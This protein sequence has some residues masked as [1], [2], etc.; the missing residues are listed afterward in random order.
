MR[1]NKIAP[2]CKPDV[3]YFRQDKCQ[4]RQ[5]FK[6]PQVSV[7]EKDIENIS[8]HID[9]INDIIGCLENRLAKVLKPGLNSVK[10]PCASQDEDISDL[11]RF[12]ICKNIDLKDIISRLDNIYKGLDL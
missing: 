10:P 12:M 11:H 6:E 3:G 9:E 7:F 8:S 5:V 4:D 2:E 1:E